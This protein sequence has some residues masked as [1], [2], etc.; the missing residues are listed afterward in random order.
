MSTTEQRDGN[1][2]EA[3]SLGSAKEQDDA[4]EVLAK[5]EYTLESILWLFVK[6]ARDLFLYVIQF[7]NCIAC[8]YLDGIIRNSNIFE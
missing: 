3:Q 2:D 7:C 4:T 6:L 1:L 8:A 5:P